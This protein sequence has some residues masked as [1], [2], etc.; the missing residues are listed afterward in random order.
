LTQAQIEETICLADACAQGMWGSAHYCMTEP[1]EVTED[2]IIELGKLGMDCIILSEFPV[3]LG[4]TCHCIS[5]TLATLAANETCARFIMAAPGGSVVR[6]V[7]ALIE[8]CEGLLGSLGWSYAPIPSVEQ[9]VSCWVCCKPQSNLYINLSIPP[10]VE[11]DPCFSHAPDVR[12]AA[13]T[14]LAFLAC[15][16]LGARGDDCLVGPFRTRLLGAGAFGA[17]LRAA[18]SSS[19]CEHCDPIIQQ[20]AAVGIMYLSTMV[21]G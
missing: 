11:D 10:K 16:P 21:G 15:H 3:D 18:L 17:L 6:S 7:L 13:C 12:A 19:A 1:M 20:T 4:R 5:A 8:V 9:N 2:H 14:T